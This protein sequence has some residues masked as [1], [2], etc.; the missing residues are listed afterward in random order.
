MQHI[1]D[2]ILIGYSFYN[3]KYIED[4]DTLIHTLNIK[5]TWYDINIIITINDSSSYMRSLTFIEIISNSICLYSY[6]LGLEGDIEALFIA[7]DF[8]FS[9]NL[10]LF[11]KG[12]GLPSFNNINQFQQKPTSND[13][14]TYTN[15][16][17]IDR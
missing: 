7:Q 16:Q 5:N 13:K 10:S 1:K 4:T 8:I 14:S 17:N 3:K 15:Y 11:I 9:N 6:D 12:F 2:K